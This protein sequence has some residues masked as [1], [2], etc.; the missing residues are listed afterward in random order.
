[1]SEDPYQKFRSLLNEHHQFPSQYTHKFIGKNSEIFK[2]SVIEFE[3]KFIGLTKST[4][5]LSASSK[6]LAL[7]Y[8][9]WAASADDVIKLTTETHKIN[10]IIYIL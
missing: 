4:E 5:R 9:Y 6:H 1:M 3:A 10:D 2:A 7:T 8:V